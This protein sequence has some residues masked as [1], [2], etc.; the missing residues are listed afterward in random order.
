MGLGLGRR[1]RAVTLG[2][3]SALSPFG[4]SHIHSN[5]HYRVPAA[6]HPGSPSTQEVKIQTFVKLWP[7]EPGFLRFAPIFARP[8]RPGW[9]RDPGDSKRGKRGGR[10]K[11]GAPRKRSPPNYGRALSSGRILARAREANTFRPPAARQDLSPGHR[12]GRLRV[13]S[14]DDWSD[15]KRR[16]NGAQ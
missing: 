11:K 14:R 2:N 4:H 16:G 7:S 12:L 6:K 13:S 9:T 5:S 3:S 15:K 10:K 8:G 1:Q